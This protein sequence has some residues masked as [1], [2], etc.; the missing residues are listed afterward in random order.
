VIR[1]FSDLGGYTS[2][3]VLKL[4]SGVYDCLIYH[5]REFQRIQ[6]PY[7]TRPNHLSYSGFQE[8]RTSLGFQQLEEEALVFGLHTSGGACSCTDL[9]FGGFWQRLG[10]F[11]FRRVEPLVSPVFSRT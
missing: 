11:F 6:R 2:Y 7:S 9:S 5:P 1:C 10:V 8:G 3:L 4:L